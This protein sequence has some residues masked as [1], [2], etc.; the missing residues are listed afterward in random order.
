MVTNGKQHISE[1]HAKQASNEVH[2]DPNKIGASTPFDFSAKNLTPYGGLLP[3]ATMLEK[4]G[5]KELVEENLIVDRNTRV[6]SSYHFLAIVMGIYL[7][8]TRLNQLRYIASD[9]LVA[10]ILKVVHLPPQCTLR[11]FLNSLHSGITRQIQSI[12]RRMR[13]A[14]WAAGNIELPSRMVNK[15]GLTANDCN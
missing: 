14:V 15:F 11:R 5:F 8:F 2:S 10:G 7:G 4:I 1:S 13:E 3:L 9:P 12:Q 6:M